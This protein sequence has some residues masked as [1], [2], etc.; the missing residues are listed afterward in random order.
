MRSLAA[1][2]LLASVA[3]LLAGCTQILPEE[4][5]EQATDEPVEAPTG[6]SES[7]VKAS[8]ETDEPSA[9]S[10]T[11]AAPI[12]PATEPVTESAPVAATPVPSAPVPTAP[13]SDELAPPAQ[14]PVPSPSPQAPPPTPTPS[15]SPAPAQPAA[16]P[17]DGSY[18]TYQYRTHSGSPDSSYSE[19]EDATVRWTYHDGDW[20]GVCAW[21]TDEFVRDRGWENTTGT[22]TLTA[23]DPPHWPPF[24][25]RTPPAQGEPV[26]TWL[27]TDCSPVPQDFMRYAGAETESA[28]VQGRPVQAPTH[29]AEDP[30]DGSPSDFRSEWSRGTGLVLYWEWQRSY[31]NL[32]GRL[33]DTDAPLG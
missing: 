11:P 10:P 4:S 13:T 26:K 28:T 29:L 31:S 23:G 33:V 16:W 14:K 5:G 2:P 18:V 19:T 20:T 1:F 24:N 15:P 17:R 22:E 8:E 25:T 12:S 6:Q 7:G 32:S 30:N 9:V 21:E 3:L 27:V